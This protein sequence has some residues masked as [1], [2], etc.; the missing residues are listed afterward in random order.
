MLLIG[1]DGKETEL[2]D[3][4][5][6]I[7]V[8][9]PIPAKSI[10]TTTGVVV[11][12][13][14]YGKFLKQCLDSLLYQTKQFD[15]IIVVDDSSTDNTKE[16][17]LSYNGAVE[18][19]YS[20]L[21]KPNGS[22][23][24]GVEKLGFEYKYLLFVDADNFISPDFHEKL[25]NI[26]EKNESLAVAYPK[27]KYF[28]EYTYKKELVIDFNHNLLRSRNFADLCALIRMDAYRQINGINEYCKSDWD[29]WLRITFLGW[30]MQLCR[31]TILHY[32]L[33]SENAH[34][35]RSVKDD[36]KETVN[37]FINTC[38]VTIVTLFSGREWNLSR[39][40]K[41][42]QNLDCNKD[43]IFIVALDNSCDEY[44]SNDLL[45]QL[46]ESGFNYTLVKDESRINE[47]P[48]SEIADQKR[49]RIAPG[50]GK[51]IQRHIAALYAKAKTFI[52]ASTDY[53]WSIEDDVVV[54]PNSLK[55]FIGAFY[56][57]PEISTLTGCIQCRFEPRLIAHTGKWG[58][59]RCEEVRPVTT[60][61]EDKLTPILATGMF[62]S[63]F[64]IEQWNKLVFSERPY[65]EKQ[66]TWYDWA[67]HH[68]VHL[69]GGKLA[70]LSSVICI[71]WTNHNYGLLP[72][73]K[74]I[75]EE[76]YENRTA[77]IQPKVSDQFVLQRHN[78]GGNERDIISNQNSQEII[79][80]DSNSNSV[81]R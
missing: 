75:T 60:V 22:R 35:I 38:R 77:T 51:N 71:H 25:F 7:L 23:K 29:M 42:L 57:R 26:L 43:N 4:S 3:S 64:R 41:S 10:G 27:I 32:R 67:V 63:I 45:L 28:E 49:H 69:N 74:V 24:L 79:P 37:I 15:R 73:N 81:R 59:K 39:Y 33:H 48:A 20:N 5:K 70:L 14:N 40:I 9:S 55:E 30:K 56:N 6:A 78:E 34:I 52:P 66:Y 2:Q 44:F 36:V 16:I 58:E 47:I 68:N 72:D 62:C 13:H 21:K 61:P 8:M 11:T 12:C 46:S 54:P 80:E 76:E 1:H 53:V 50:M 17:I 18:Y 65:T 19:L 31:D